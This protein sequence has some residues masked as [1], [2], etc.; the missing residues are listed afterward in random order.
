VRLFSE[1]KIMIII[2]YVNVSN[3]T[4]ISCYYEDVRQSLKYTQNVSQT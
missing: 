4:D 1:I 2:S 3:L